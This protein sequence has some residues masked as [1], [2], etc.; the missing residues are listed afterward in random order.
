[1]KLENHQNPKAGLLLLIN[2][3][4][5]AIKVNSLD[6]GFN[7]YRKD[8]EQRLVMGDQVMVIVSKR[9]GNYICILS[10]HGLCWVNHKHM[11][12]Q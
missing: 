11:S 8:S 1:M 2:E 6:E 7:F 10:K 12:N 4:T 3:H 9:I 5:L